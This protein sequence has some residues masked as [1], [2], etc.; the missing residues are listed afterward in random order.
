MPMPDASSNLI[1]SSTEPNSSLDSYFSLFENL[2][3]SVMIIKGNQFIY[4]N[5]AT[6]NELGYPDKTRFLKL[7]PWDISP[8]FQS[9]G[10]SSKQKALDIIALTHHQGQY[11]FDW[12]HQCYDGKLIN[13]LVTLT[14]IR[15]MNQSLLHVSWSNNCKNELLIKQLKTSSNLQGAIFNS[16]NFSCIATDVHGMIQLFNIGAE[17]LLGYKA[18]EVINIMTPTDLSVTSELQHRA[19]N[20]SLEFNETIDSGFS[21]LVYKAAR[22]IEDIYELNYVCKSGHFLPVQI[23][24]TALRDEDQIIIGYLLIATDNTARKLLEN[25]QFNIASAFESGLAMFITDAQGRY[26]HVNKAYSDM[27]GYSQSELIGKNPNMMKSERQDSEFYKNMW[28]AIHKQGHWS[29]EIWNKRKNG[30]IHLELLNINK[31]TDHF[32][33]TTHFVATFADIEHRKAYE[34][35]LSKTQE[36][37]HKLIIETQRSEELELDV[38]KAKQAV[39]TKSEFL[40]NMSH[41]IRTPINAI[42]SIAFLTLQTDLTAQQQNYL[43]KINSSAKWLLGILDDIL[44]FSKLEAGKV[45]LEQNHFELD[46]IIAFLKTVTTPLVTNK[47]LNLN[48]EVE[49]SVPTVLIG[50]SLRL[51]QVLL[52]LMSNAI[53]FTHSGS[54]TLNVKLITLFDQ[55]AQLKFSVTD[56]GIG[57]DINHKNELFVAFNQADNSTTRLYGGTGLGLSI[58]KEL[59]SAMGGTISVESQV[60]TGSCFSFVICLA[61]AANP[62]PHAL[63]ATSL[64]HETTYPSLLNARILVVEDNLMIQEFIPD[65][66]GYEGMIVDLANNGVEALALLAS[67]DYA[68]ILM[69]CQMPIMDGFEAT[70]RIR[71]NPRYNHLPIIAMTGNVAES[72]RQRCFDCGMND[73][74]SKPVDWDQ[75]FLILDRLISLGS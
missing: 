4:C 69:D 2:L 67:N 28:E 15:V 3:D 29:G 70:Q 56:T 48:L 9:D 64:K 51:G 17:A 44:S 62:V 71:T 65:I 19:K 49:P 20:L 72:D 74:I 12:Q 38:A 46:A 55:Q 22:G 43:S 58:S 11:H 5:A 30:E 47:D 8:E 37:I 25:N 32:G 41:E 39:L 18:N 59:V 52:N 61:V 35:N 33:N 24:I 42:M 40:S 60:D 54:I 75:A 73:F 45:E 63:P 7:T 31:T 66:L 21:A 13:V 57:L 34:D 53:K 26:I 23:S 6:L 68:A 36:Q 50:D 10:L 1:H 16:R 27:T 14:A